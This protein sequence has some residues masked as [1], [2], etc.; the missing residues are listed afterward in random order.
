M[1]VVNYF[2]HLKSNKAIFIGAFL[3]I[4]IGLKQPQW[5]GI[6]SPLGEFYLNMLTMCVLPILL[7]AIALSI[8]RLLKQTGNAI[9]M[10]RLIM[11]FLSTLFLASCVGS[12]A[13][14][15]FNP[16]NDMGEQSMVAIG[17]II[18]DLSAPDLQVNLFIP[19]EE[20]EQR[21]LMQAFFFTLVPSNI[22]QA[23]SNGAT[24]KVLFFA[25]LLGFAIGTLKREVSEHICISFEAV[26]SAFTK[27]VQW[28]MY[29]FP[30]GL[31]GLL[32]ATLSKIGSDALLAMVK[33]VPLVIFT[34]IFWFLI[35]SLFIWY[36]TGSLWHSMSDLK[37]PITLS[38]ATSN[39]M[40][41][42]PAALDVM[43][44]RFGYDKQNVDLLIPLTF[45]LCRIGPTLYFALAT[46]FVVQIYN[47]QVDFGTVIVIILGSLIAGTATA[48]SSGVSMLTML[49]LVSG[50]LGLPLDAVLIL[51][52][53]VDPIIAPFRVLAIV[54]SSCAIITLVLPKKTVVRHPDNQTITAK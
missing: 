36:R 1:G 38:L 26:Y 30:F 15:M 27:M 18:Q 14:L 28:M 19:Y 2:Q 8:G 53:V 37:E 12:L 33:F 5:V 52:V 10:K 23:L 35:M 25:I 29:I 46:V 47:L 6:V 3:G 9:S 17:N 45:T 20:P 42:L 54:H 16:G 31:C 13:G 4:Y 41:S 43:S 51:F 40:A 50:P 48:G 44:K 49:S 24:I 11:V 22:F 21:S 34:F 39:T 7:T 32:A